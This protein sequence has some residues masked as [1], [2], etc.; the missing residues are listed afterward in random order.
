MLQP[1]TSLVAC[2][3]LFRRC[4]QLLWHFFTECY[5]KDRG[6]IPPAG[7]TRA[8]RAR[9]VGIAGWYHILVQ[10]AGKSKGQ[11]FQSLFLNSCSSTP[12]RASKQA[13]EMPKLGAREGRCNSQGNC[14]R[15]GLALLPSSLDA[16]HLLKGIRI[17]EKTGRQSWER[18]FAVPS[19]P[20]QG[21][22]RTFAKLWC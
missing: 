4:H 7:C 17:G 5:L 8:A 2:W 10:Q 22:P 6:P 11:Q 9:D 19:R 20:H 12:Q 13:A 18:R 15:S 21:Q 16:F 1:H 3:S 14:S